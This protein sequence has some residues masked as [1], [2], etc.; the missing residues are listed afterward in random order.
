MKIL[1]NLIKGINSSA[2]VITESSHE[3]SLA[4]DETSQGAQQVAGTISQLA[5]GSQKQT[6]NV[7][8]SL[9]NIKVINN[10]IQNISGHAVNAV[11]M[12][13]STRENAV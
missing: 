7:N 5:Q 13:E 2:N 1:R 4:S 11:K 8:S 10:A 9:E 3:V 12:S 6:D